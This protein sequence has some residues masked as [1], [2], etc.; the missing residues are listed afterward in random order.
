V[1]D[2][3]LESWSVAGVV[4]VCRTNP[5]GVYAKWKILC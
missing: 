2:I 4:C 1:E 5:S 3:V